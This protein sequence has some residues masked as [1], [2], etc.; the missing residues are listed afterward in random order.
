V[1]FNK[2]LP[3]VPKV[4]APAPEPVVEAA[5]V[6]ATITDDD[7]LPDTP[8]DAAPRTLPP[9]ATYTLTAT[10]I[11]AIV[12]AARAGDASAD[13]PSIADVISQGITTGLT[14]HMG[15]RQ[16]R[17]G[18]IKETH[19]FNPDGKKRELKR[20]FFQ[21]G[22]PIL[23]RCVS[24]QEIEMLHELVDG[25][26]GT[27]EFPIHVHTKKKLGNKDRTWI[28]YDGSRDGR[29]RLKDYGR[30]FYEILNNLVRQAKE[31]KAQR[32][33]DLRAQLAED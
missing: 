20:E 4:P 5:P 23:E 7:L 24:D 13:H 18:E 25:V 2:G 21:N 11:A 12:Q 14:Q 16:K 10:D 28:D 33:A 1:A 9:P 27:P 31:Q 22:A 15:P 29:N 32:K 30:T 26:Y 6:M 19:V 3:K 8:V 17:P